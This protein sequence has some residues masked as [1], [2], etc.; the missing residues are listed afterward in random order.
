[1]FPYGK[2]TNQF[3]D[4]ECGKIIYKSQFYIKITVLKIFVQ[5]V[6]CTVRIQQIRRLSNGEL[7]R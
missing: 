7:Q 4:E 6:L 2:L 3:I 1:M 5:C